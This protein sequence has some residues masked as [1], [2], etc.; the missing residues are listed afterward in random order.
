MKN[1]QNAIFFQEL[2]QLLAL[3]RRVQNQVENVTVA[4]ALHGLPI[5][6]PKWEVK[7]G[8]TFG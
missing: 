2:L 4:R 8:D 6:E 1:S 5:R 3:S 7:L